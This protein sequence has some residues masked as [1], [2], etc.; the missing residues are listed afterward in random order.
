VDIWADALVGGHDILIS[1][2]VHKST[3]QKNN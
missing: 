1:G 2:Y 3:F